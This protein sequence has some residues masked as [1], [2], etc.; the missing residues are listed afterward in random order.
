[1]RAARFQPL[2]CTVIAAMACAACQRYPYDPSKASRPYPKQLSQGSV[3]DMQVIPD[4]NGGTLTVVNPTATTYAN[5]DLW[6]NQRYVRH[7]DSLPAGEN[8]VLDINTFWDE[9]GEG[10]FPGGWFRY[11][12][13]TPIVLVQIQTAP[14]KP[15]IGLVAKP[16]DNPQR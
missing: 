3:V 7:V 2:A 1:M 8:L 12:E 4:V 15:L 13:P 11:F 14:D 16:P 9:R 6:L 10:P 5:F